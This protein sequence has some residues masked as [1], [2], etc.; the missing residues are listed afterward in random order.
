MKSL[1]LS[2]QCKFDVAC[3]WIQ[4]ISATRV[5]VE[6]SAEL[7]EQS[8]VHLMSFCQRGFSD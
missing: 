6:T 3:R 1:L 2:R 5:F 8:N 4:T 7:I